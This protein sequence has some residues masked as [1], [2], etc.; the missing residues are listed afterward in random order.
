MRHRLLAAL[1]QIGPTGILGAL[2]TL[3]LIA[4][5]GGII[6]ILFLQGFPALSVNFIF[7]R[8]S[9]EPSEGGIFNA[10][11]GTALLTLLMT[12]AALP[13]GVA[14][15]IY[16]AE[17]AKPQSK[18]TKI[19]RVAIESLAGIPSVVYGLFGLGFFVLFVGK[20]LDALLSEPP[21]VVWAK[22]GIL[23]S[24]LTLAVLTLP[25]VIVSTEEAIRRV[26][27]E[28]RQAAYALGATRLQ[29]LLWV[30]LPGARAGIGTGAV[31][32]IGRAAGEVAPILFTGAANHVAELPRHPTDMHMHLAYHVYALAT[33]SADVESA[34]KLI[35]ATSLVLVT[36]T[37]LLTGIG[38]LLRAK[39]KQPENHGKAI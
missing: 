2:S 36:I 39:N 37:M 33:Q 28:L 23:W 4:M 15:G 7:G 24:S 34:K 8:S 26:S 18:L 14:T 9:L 10:L 13:L 38:S 27:Q 21:L 16:F 11:V 20:S 25:V 12:A 5:L 6:A 31:L 1:V 19:L 3:L 22:P 17:Y 30:V 32:A 29:V 35:F